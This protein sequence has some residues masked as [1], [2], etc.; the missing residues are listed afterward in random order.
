VQ[1]LLAT[2]ANNPHYE[3]ILDVH[4]FL[5]RLLLNFPEDKLLKI[6]V[7]AVF[8]KAESEIGRYRIAMYLFLTLWKVDLT[9]LKKAFSK[10]EDT[11]VYLSQ[12]CEEVVDAMIL[13]LL[14]LRDRDQSLYR[15]ALKL[16]RH[17]VLK[18][19]EP[20]IEI[21][22]DKFKKK[23]SE[24]DSS[25]WEFRGTDY[26]IVQV[27][28]LY[29]KSID[30]YIQTLG[31]PLFPI[32]Q[33]KPSTEP[34]AKADKDSLEYDSSEE[35]ESDNSDQ[36]SGRENVRVKRKLKSHSKEKKRAESSKSK[37]PKEK[38]TSQPKKKAKIAVKDK[39]KDKESSKPKSISKDKLMLKL[40]KS[41]D[42]SLNKVSSL[43][44]LISPPSTAHAH[45]SNANLTDQRRHRHSR[46]APSPEEGSLAIDMNKFGHLGKHHVPTSDP[47][48]N[49]DALGS[50][51]L[52]SEEDLLNDH[53]RH[54]LEGT[55]KLIPSKRDPPPRL[56]NKGV[57]VLIEDLIL[58]AEK[59]DIVKLHVYLSSEF[60]KE[61]KRMELLDNIMDVCMYYLHF[62]NTP[63]IPHVRLV[64]HI[65]G[66][67]LR[68]KFC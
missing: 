64:L 39:S 52:T 32:P 47:R 44:G 30:E 27:S 7:D 66:E 59:A 14:A 61:P 60:Y 49:R 41:R 26:R 11:F 57:I 12:D 51:H 34:N 35:E 28:P 40:D 17:S 13:S 20:R 54:V 8:Q 2:L 42:K 25:A 4:T 67:Y 36:S 21:L 24:A 43:R 38:S 31:D 45:K 15:R 63:F 9:V 56:Y 53:I 16:I 10:V 5:S 18:T 46:E 22:K 58:G 65:L 33:A 37:K 50:N 1:Q 23:L 29:P 6:V 19:V 62:E 55:G 48:I 68:S 3:L